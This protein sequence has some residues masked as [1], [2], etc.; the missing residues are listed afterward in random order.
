MRGWRVNFLLRLTSSH[1]TGL[2]PK[3]MRR[4]FN[5]LT[6]DI[7]SSKPTLPRQMKPTLLIS[8]MRFEENK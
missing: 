3:S 4:D 1:L 6:W 7:Q 5:N 2:F 8:D